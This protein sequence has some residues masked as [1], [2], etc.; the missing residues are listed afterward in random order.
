M[1]HILTSELTN[2]LKEFKMLERFEQMALVVSLS[3]LVLILLLVILNLN[4]R[5]H[6]R[7]VALEGEQIR[8]SFSRPMQRYGMNDWVQISPEIDHKLA[9]AGNDLAIILREPPLADTN[10]KLTINENATDIYGDTFAEEYTHRI[11][12]DPLEFAFIRG[13]QLVESNL[14]GEEIVLYETYEGGE[15][16]GFAISEKYIAVQQRTEDRRRRE[17]VV[18]DKND[19]AE[20]IFRTRDDIDIYQLELVDSRPERLLLLE[21][22]VYFEQGLLF[23]DGG[24]GI[25]VIDLEEVRANSRSNV[26]REDTKQKLQLPDEIDDIESFQLARDSRSL[27]IKDGF[28]QFF[29]LIDLAAPSELTPLGTFLDSGGFNYTGD[30]VV[31][32][33]VEVAE[34]FSQPFLLTIDAEQNEQRLTD[35][36]VYAVDPQFFND[37]SNRLVFAR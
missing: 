6:V 37:R 23:P 25:S 28:T 16:E 11:Q 31:F 20:E 18:L 13:E 24:R 21:Q 2:R 29:Y 34:R 22:K 30:T 36:L 19:Q 10:Y 17:V 15:I 4:V 32:N 14:K 33:E 26:I 7:A 35:G 5:P 1:T 27:L 9:W 8:I 12:T 3:L